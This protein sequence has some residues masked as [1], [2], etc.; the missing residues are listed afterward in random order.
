[1]QMLCNNEIVV[2]AAEASFKRFY[3][4]FFQVEKRRKEDKKERYSRAQKNTKAIDEICK[5]AS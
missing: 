3:L 1:M 2:I 5:L 4:P